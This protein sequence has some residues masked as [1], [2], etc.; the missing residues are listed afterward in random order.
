MFVCKRRDFYL[1]EYRPFNAW[2][3]FLQ[4][5]NAMIFSNPFI[6]KDLANVFKDII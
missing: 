1:L 5:V 2:K 4:S 3:Y 6:S